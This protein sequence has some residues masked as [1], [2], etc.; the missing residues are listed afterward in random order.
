[1]IQ[2]SNI[3]VVDISKI[4]LVPYNRDK[5]Y[6]KKFKGIEKEGEKT[7]TRCQQS[8]S[9]NK[10]SICR[11][12]PFDK[13]YRCKKCV[14]ELYRISYAKRTGRT[15][16]ELKANKESRGKIIDGKK[17]C[18]KC[19]KWK[20]T[21]SFM[22]WGYIKCGLYPSCKNCCSKRSYPYQFKDTKRIKLECMIGYGGCC[23][24]CGDSRIE[25]LTIE[26]IRYRGFKHDTYGNTLILMKKLIK[27]EFPEGYTV[28]CA[29]CNQLTRHNKPCI[30]SQEWLEHYNKKIKPYQYPRQKELNILEKKWAAMNGTG[31]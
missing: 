31:E 21:N 29:G 10:F 13:N 30:H 19:K 28:L 11:G 27:L 3:E 14:D 5:H 9:L 22:G 18:S 8:K 7:C 15:I 17:M 6:A 1:M 26:H 4:E 20:P 25:M 16:E 24:C 12:A 23:Q 2:Q